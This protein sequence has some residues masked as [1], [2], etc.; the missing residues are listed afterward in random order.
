MVTSDMILPR[1]KGLK[2][3]FMAISI[4]MIQTLELFTLPV[5]AVQSIPVVCMYVV[6]V[7]KRQNVEA[8]QKRKGVCVC[9]C[10]CVQAFG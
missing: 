5:Q 6:R 2:V 4:Y 3:Y 7:R 9:A 8:A 10:V 1:Y